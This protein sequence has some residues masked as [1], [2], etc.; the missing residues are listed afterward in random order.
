MQYL[1][2]NLEIRKECT[3][4][5]IGNWSDLGRSWEVVRKR[6]RLRLI[7]WRIVND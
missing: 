2:S 1:K 4:A 3:V 6:W 5:S 7:K